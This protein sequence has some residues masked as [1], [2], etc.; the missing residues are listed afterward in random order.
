MCH[1]VQYRNQLGHPVN[2]NDTPDLVR[3]LSGVKIVAVAAGED[4]SLA[5]SADGFVHCVL[6]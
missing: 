6:R 3:G 5:L 2:A 1:S 4:H